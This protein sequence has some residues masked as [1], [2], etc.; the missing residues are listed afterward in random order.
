M[1]EP[2]D[3]GKPVL[4][5]LTGRIG[6]YE[7]LSPL[8]KGAMGMVYK[9][10]DTDLDRGVA[11]K[12]MVAQIAEDPE[13]KQRFE[14]EAK[15][16][17]K[18]NH[19][20]VVMVFDRGTHT[21]GSPYIVM[22]LLKGRDLQKQM[23]QPP[24][25][26]LDRKVFVIVQVLA[27]LAHAH[28]A[29][30]V[31]RDIKP[32]NI[33]INEDGS[34]KIMD[35]GVA[36][37][38]AASM[39]GT[40]NVMGTADYMSPEQVQ[41]QKVDCRSD[42]F[43]VGCMLFELVAGRRP[44]HA[45]NLMAIFYKI[46]HED[47]NFELVPQGGDYD[48]LMPVLRKALA[49]KIEDRY[50]TA[51][52][53]ALDLREWLKGHATGAGAQSA[54]AQ[55]VDLEAPTRPPVP[56]TQADFT[57]EAAAGATVDIG[58]RR[59]GPLPRRTATGATRAGGATVVD[60]AAG[61]TVRPGATRVVASPR[62]A[63][64]PAPPPERA[65]VLP[66][67]GVVLGLVAV[68][69]VGYVVWK[70][71]QPLAPAVTL[72]PSTPPVTAAPAVATPTAPPV[73]S[74]PPPTFPEPEGKAAA[75]VRAAR[76]AFTAGD[77]DRAV[78]QA[79]QALREDPANATAS[80]ILARA[81]AGQK[82]AVRL[83]AAEA[84]LARRDWAAAEGEAA[85]A[86]A[87]APWYGP[88]AQFGGRIEAARAQAQRE[89]DAAAQ[90]QRGAQLVALLAEANGAM[91]RK[92]Y[93]AAI[94]AYNRVLEADP[95]NQVALIG[96]NN[97]LT[98]KTV[99]ESAAAG[100][101]R[102]TGVVRTFVAGRTEK[103]GAEG[104]AGLVGFEDSAGVQV[105][106]GTQAAELPGSIAF[107]AVPAAPR[108]GERFRVSVFLVNEGGQPIPL[109]SLTLATTVNGK[110][111]SGPVPLSAATVA[112]GSRAQ[113]FQTPGETIWRDDT[114]S[115]SMEVVV[116]TAKGESYRNTLTWK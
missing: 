106:K 4:K 41:G 53:F 31:H 2:S 85:A 75:A 12:V 1:P 11:L 97:A 78:A 40:G 89:A 49:K 93:E 50:Q 47:P 101:G 110:R 72:A 91:E 100:G 92:Q 83:K 39:T 32:A 30:L 35:F 7:I 99:A 90:Q 21:D 71:Q 36:H 17:A 95:A 42:L 14:R 62:P 70:G 112:P 115:W 45:D 103:K 56:M 59:T 20:N 5:E 79:Q 87:A 9:A 6:K 96:K 69:G 61:A 107:E 57:A 54:L 67:V 52:E 44:F 98:A 84:A 116:R 108:A 24:P 64:R 16:V 76:G 33:W 113:V 58:S 13:L 88:A 104:A 3:P 80:D 105:K 38:S 19:P 82:A 114:A 29:G 18:L 73:T 23:R 102:A 74:A 43:A 10:H 22:E 48:D 65:S 86:L 46:L 77:Y 66:W 25:L 28:Q 51:Q 94:A 68:G 27:G 111:Q 81:I 60:P 55:L 109:A 34:A 15:A 8:G 63:A 37:V 26:A